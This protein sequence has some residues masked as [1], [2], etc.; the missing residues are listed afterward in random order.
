MVFFQFA[1]LLAAAF[2]LAAVV[3]V[4]LADAEA[5]P[6][7]EAEADHPKPHPPPQ[8][9]PPSPPSYPVAYPPPYPAY[10]QPYPAH[11][12][13]SYPAYPQPYPPPA[14][15]GKYTSEKCTTKEWASET[16]LCTPK[17]VQT[18]ENLE[19]RVKKVRD[20]KTMCRPAMIP[21][22]KIQNESKEQRVCN[23]KVINKRSTLYATLYEQQ[24]VVR[25]NTHYETK[26]QKSYG[27]APRCYSVPVK[28]RKEFL[29]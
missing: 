8:E 10:P 28:V 7:A 25:C 21:K 4:A 23:T 15:Y 29:E 13:A 12:P 2:S 22:C 11:Y 24:M 6:K 19:V 14:P 18:C 20:P 5:K 9:Y 27:Y 3:G 26:C 1:T 16:E 17:A